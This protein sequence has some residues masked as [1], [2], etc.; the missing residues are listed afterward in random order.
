MTDAPLPPSM[1]LA[2]NGWAFRG[3]PSLPRCPRPCRSEWSP[4]TGS[5]S[6][7]STPPYGGKVLRAQVDLEP[8][9]TGPKNSN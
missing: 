5:C 6:A 8:D 3:N 9:W 4:G 2:R 1:H 7:P